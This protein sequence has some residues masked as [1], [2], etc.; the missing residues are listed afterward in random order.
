MVHT[1]R[2]LNA[3]PVLLLALAIPPAPADAQTP[4]PD[5]QG[6]DVI[7]RYRYRVLGLF[8]KQTGGPI[9]GADVI[10]VLSGNSVKT[11]STGTASLL[12]M[13][14]GG[15]LVRIRKLG[16]EMQTIM[17]PIS[18]TDTI[19]VTMVLERATELP[20]VV[21]TATAERYLSPQ[22]RGFEDRRLNHNTGYF[23]SEADLRKEGGRMLGLALM[24]HIPTIRI[25]EGR[26]SSMLLQRSMRCGA[27]GPPD[28]YIDGVPLAHLPPPT[29]SGKIPPASGAQWPID[30]SQFQTEDFAGA[31]YYPTTSAT[32]AQYG[33]TTGACGVLLLWTREK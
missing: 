2:I 4:A 27:G 32:P 22:L 21:T 18:P 6:A 25:E 8:D 15:G 24:A 33:G 20:A 9:E 12:F 13:P 1:R 14:D 3:L 23:I 19:P 5:A 17:L 7:P 30:L 26:A 16:Y 29:P 31:E 11:T 10:D 28:V